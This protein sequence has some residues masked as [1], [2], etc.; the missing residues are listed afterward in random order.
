MNTTARLIPLFGT[1]CLSSAPAAIIWQV[2]EN[3]NSHDSVNAQTESLLYYGNSANLDSLQESSG[4]GSKPGSAIAKDDD[5]YFAGTYS[6]VMD[7]SSYTPVGMVASHEASFER[8]LTTGNR[9]SRIHFNLD[10]SHD[11][12][13]IFRLSVDHNHNNGDASSQFNIELR[14]N[15][16]PIGSYTHTSA[17]RNNIFQSDEFTLAS[18]GAGLNSADDNYVELILTNTPGGGGTYVTFD[19][20]TLEQVPEPSALFLLGTGALL[21]LRRRR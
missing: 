12:G 16:N 10:S 2:G 9:N 13:D 19:Q 15:G 8:A 21:G 14:F 3:N 7:G 4:S 11:P 5:F 20:I 17:T 18:V 6:T 1:L